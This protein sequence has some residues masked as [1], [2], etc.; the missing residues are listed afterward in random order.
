MI[1]IQSAYALRIEA[2]QR[3]REENIEWARKE[4]KLVK[5][6]ERIRIEAM[7]F[8]Q[9][10][11]SISNDDK[12]TEMIISQMLFSLEKLLQKLWSECTSDW[13]LKP[14]RKQIASQI[15]SR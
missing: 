15:L 11:G 6:E 4:S 12:Q 1:Q 3:E 10:R 8:T 5:D 14:M 2:A 7:S 13:R 9:L